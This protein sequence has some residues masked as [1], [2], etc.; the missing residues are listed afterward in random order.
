MNDRQPLISVV[1]CTYNRASLLADLLQTVCQQ[2]LPDA[3]YEVIVVD[4]NSSDATALVSQRFV[5]RYPHMRY[6]REPQ[7][8]LSHARNC[9]WQAAQGL[10]VAYL[11]DDCQ[12]LPGWLAAAQAVI[13]EVGAEVFGGPYTAFYNSPKAAWFQDEYGSWPRWLANAE[14]VA[15]AIDCATDVAPTTLHG[16][17]LFVRRDLLPLAGGFAPH[18]GMKGAQMAFGEETALMVRLHTLRP[19]TRFYYDPRLRVCHLVRPEKLSIWWQLSSTITY[20][21]AAYQV[22][23]PGQQPFVWWLC[24]LLPFHTLVK[25]GGVFLKCWLWRNRERHPYWQ[26]YLYESKELSYYLHRLGVWSA[27]VQTWWASRN[28]K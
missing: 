2:H 26:N 14:G 12:T 1:I 10:Y 15:V 17:N 23:Q 21:Q 13:T 3:D 22:Y 7:Q 28:T 16:G 24:L 8:G 6:Y 18:L 5:T 27:Y 20:G 9:G 19:A 11:D 25:S 4:N